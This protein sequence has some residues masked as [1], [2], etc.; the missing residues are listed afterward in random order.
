MRCCPGY[1]CPAAKR[2]EIEKWMGTNVP[3]HLMDNMNYGTLIS[4]PGRCD[5]TLRER[6]DEGA[7]CLGGGETMGA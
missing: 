3:V 6:P 5:E 2:V 7:S 1:A 4:R